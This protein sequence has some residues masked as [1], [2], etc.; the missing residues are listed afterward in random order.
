[1]KKIYY[2]FG[3]LLVVTILVCGC[4][5]GKINIIT[6]GTMQIS[7]FAPMSNPVPITV[8]FTAANTGNA[9][10]KDVEEDIQFTYNGTIIKTYREYFGEINA[11]DTKV[12]DD[13]IVVTLQP[14]TDIKLIKMTF[15]ST[16][17]NGQPLQPSS[18]T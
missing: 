14:G 8:H 18:T 2:V 7:G 5:G 10:A 3:I 17:V 12:V 4:T 15:G 1:M 13:T 16:Y 6:Q 9:D 11:G